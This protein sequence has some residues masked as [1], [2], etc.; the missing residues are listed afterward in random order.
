MGTL[1]KYMKGRL[2][3]QSICCFCYGVRQI[4]RDGLFK[5]EAP[6]PVCAQARTSGT[7][8]HPFSE[9]LYSLAIGLQLK[10]P[11]PSRSIPNQTR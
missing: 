4:S 3:S 5:V 2:I 8:N 7:R 10:R 1:F 6:F 11:P 9:Q